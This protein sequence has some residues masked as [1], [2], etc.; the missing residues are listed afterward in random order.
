[1]AL[2]IHFEEEAESDVLVAIDRL[3]DEDPPLATAFYEAVF[4]ALHRLAAYP[5]I[6]RRYFDVP[7]ER[8]RGVRVWVLR[9]FSDLLF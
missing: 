2:R 9:R 4:E 1:M 8:L 5:E 7:D 6:G 3:G